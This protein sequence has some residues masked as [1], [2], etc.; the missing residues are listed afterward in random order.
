MIDSDQ[1]QRLQ[2]VWWT[3]GNRAG[4][5]DIWQ[6]LSRAA[7]PQRF[8][9]MDQHLMPMVVIVFPVDAKVS[10]GHYFF[11]PH[12]ET[13]IDKEFADASVITVGLDFDQ[14]VHDETADEVTLHPFRMRVYAEEQPSKE[15]TIHEGVIELQP[16]PI[17]WT[18][19]SICRTSLLNQ[20]LIQRRHQLE[21]QRRQLEEI[22]LQSVEVF[23]ALEASSDNTPEFLLELAVEHDQGI[24]TQHGWAKELWVCST[25]T[26]VKPSISVLLLE[27]MV[28]ASSACG[29]DA[30]S[31]RNPS[32]VEQLLEKNK[33]GMLATNLVNSTI[34]SPYSPMSQSG[35]S[36]ASSEL[37]SVLSRIPDFISHVK[38]ES[39]RTSLP[40]K[41]RDR[42][43]L[44]S[45]FCIGM[46]SPCMIGGMKQTAAEFLSGRPGAMEAKKSFPTMM[47]YSFTSHCSDAE[48]QFDNVRD[49]QHFNVVQLHGAT[50][51]L[52][53]ETEAFLAELNDMVSPGDIFVTASVPTVLALLP[54]APSWHFEP[55][56]FWFEVAAW[57]YDLD[58]RIIWLSPNAMVSWADPP[59][60]FEIENGALVD[61]LGDFLKAAAEFQKKTKAI[62]CDRKHNK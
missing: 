24:G 16:K 58:H 4:H 3:D 17:A 9:F 27:P 42:M 10:L 37:F 15:Y 12:T 47:V 8:N 25:T 38:A 26:P 62:R 32:T 11:A 19:N 49:L 39:I 57:S 50:K 43:E 14:A 52:D 7:S 33:T 41:R 5:M 40:R 45:D 36:S 2:L 54:K 21:E 22:L 56:V 31:M 34:Q 28:K 30:V 60:V 29:L 6:E 59:M 44:Q 48:G 35:R 18:G 1:P 53:Q 46:A 13:V 20:I 55:R 23:N 51:G 61:F